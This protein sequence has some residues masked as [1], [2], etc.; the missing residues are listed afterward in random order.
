MAVHLSIL[1][2]VFRL[3]PRQSVYLPLN[4]NQLSHVLLWRACH[5]KH[6]AIAGS[7]CTVLLH[8]VAKLDMDMLK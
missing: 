2:S 7:K 4:M 6:L 3:W 1:G 5:M 8:D